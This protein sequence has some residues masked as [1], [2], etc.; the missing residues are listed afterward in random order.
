LYERG[1]GLVEAIGFFFVS[2]KKRWWVDWIDEYF[3]VAAFIVTEG[4]RER[5]R[6]VGVALDNIVVSPFLL[7]SEIAQAQSILRL[8]CD[9][10]TPRLCVQCLAGSLVSLSKAI[11]VSL[12][13]F[14][15]CCLCLASLINVYLS[16]SLLSL[17]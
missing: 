16:L 9:P 14:S 10:S 17:R 5:V 8:N 4:E 12:K 13:S 3:S 1:V 11:R 15:N 7:S 6:R 2:K